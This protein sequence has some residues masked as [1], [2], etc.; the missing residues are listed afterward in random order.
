MFAREI[1]KDQVV[2]VIHNGEVIIEYRD[3]KPLPSKLILGFIHN[4]PLHV[5]VAYDNKLEK[6]IVITTYYPDTFIWGPDFKI[7]R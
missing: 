1:S 6:C 3:D 4:E 7:R 5:V 2:Y